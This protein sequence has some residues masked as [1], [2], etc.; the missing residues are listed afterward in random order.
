MNPLKIVAIA[1]AIIMILLF[2]VCVVYL[3]V[4]PILKAVR[5][6]AKAVVERRATVIAKRQEFWGGVTASPYTT[7][8]YVTFEMESQDRI[9][10]EVEDTDYGLIIEGD[11]GIL[12]S[13]GDTFKGFQREQLKTH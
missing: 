11:S 1:I 4:E 10:L 12:L 6:G 8:Y 2:A 9:E 5:D 7:S 13:Q 3:V